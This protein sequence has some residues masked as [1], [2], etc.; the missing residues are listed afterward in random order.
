MLVADRDISCRMKEALHCADM[1]TLDS[2]VERGV[3]IPIEVIDT[4]ISVHSKKFRHPRF[5][6]S[7]GCVMQ[8][9]SLFFILSANIMALVE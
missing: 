2:K 3:M 5:V 1:S 9:C 8:G 7:L 4:N 6:A